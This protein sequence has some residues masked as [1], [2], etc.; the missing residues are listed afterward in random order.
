MTANHLLSRKSRSRGSDGN[1][2]NFRPSSFSASRHDGGVSGE[3]LGITM[4]YMMLIYAKENGSATAEETQRAAAAHWALM[5]EAS[6]RG[7]LRGADP[8][9]PTSTAT[10]VRV[11]AG[12]V[13]VI[14]GPFAETKEQLAGYYI[15][16]C[17]NLDEAL[18]WAAK[19]P[20]RRIPDNPG[21]CITTA[22]RRKLV[23]AARRQQTRQAKQD[24]LEREALASVAWQEVSSDEA[25]MTYREDRLRLI[26]TC[27][28][29]ALNRE[30]QVAL[31]LRTLGGLT[32][33]EIA[34]A[35]LVPEGTLAQRLV[36]A[37]AKIRDA[38]IPYEVP[39]PRTLPERLASVQT[40]IYLVFNEGY[41][42]TAGEDRIRRDLCAEAI[43]LGRTRRGVS[44][45]FGAYVESHRA[46]LYCP[47]ARASD[48]ALSSAA[49][50]TVRN[51]AL[52]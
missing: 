18:E 43:R 9:Q 40:V 4:R 6:R 22:A 16:E 48:V 14:D 26:F 29:P 37:K 31:T 33:A 28:H 38:R 32:T 30:A 23:D 44:A 25:S 8:L 5:E 17:D 42:A 49:Y 1:F 47:T 36:R 34:R 13:V 15:L 11:E 52:G 27:C 2:R 35:F 39:G 46:G 45:G 3:A 41:A 24:P 21:A 7:V 50:N 51:F 10:T 12:K 20:S 19:I